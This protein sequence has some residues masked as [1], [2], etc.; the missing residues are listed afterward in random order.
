M[1]NVSAAIFV[2]KS[3]TREEVEGR[4]VLD[5]GSYNY[6]GS[7]APLIKSW[8]PKE[9]IGIDILP[10][11]GVDLVCTAEDI[12]KIFGENRFDVVMCVE[13]LEHAK[14]W[15]EVI[16]NLK[17]VVAPGGVLV[18]TT[19]SQGFP[20]HG[21][22]D[23]YWRYELSDFKTIFSDMQVQAL[24][25]DSVEPG[26]FIKTIKND[27]F[28]EIDLKEIA[29]HSVLL[30]KKIVVLPDSLNND[31]YYRKLALKQKLRKLAY[32]VIL[33]G[34]KKISEILG[35]SSNPSS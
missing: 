29:L 4:R 27:N 18:V 19:R 10:G 22:P 9:Y 20:V 2:A 26:V 23:D 35:I 7:V 34:G 16:S 8:N 1:P 5:V 30:N 21:F 33:G 32:G 11:P 12:I 6:N 3:L 28:K 17:R 15:R 13:V 14:K 31:P 25:S 24:E